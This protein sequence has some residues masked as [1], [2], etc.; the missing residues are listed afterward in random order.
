MSTYNNTQAGQTNMQAG[1][2]SSATT[3]LVLVGGAIVAAAALAKK[4]RSRLRII[5]ESANH[6]NPI[7]SMIDAVDRRE[8]ALRKKF[9]SLQQQLRELEDAPLTPRATAQEVAAMTP[10]QRV[11]Y[12]LARQ[13]AAENLRSLRARLQSEVQLVQNDLRQVNS[14]WGNVSSMIS[15]NAQALGCIA[16]NL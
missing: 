7:D 15:S 13:E 10:E 12:N 1:Q 3:G 4:R 5:E 16:R 8:K 6:T 11:A 2:T 9:D 14:Q